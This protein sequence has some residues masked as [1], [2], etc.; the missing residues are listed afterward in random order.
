M[1]AIIRMNDRF[2]NCYSDDFKRKVVEER[3]KH[4][5][6]KDQLRAKYGIKGKSAILDWIRKFGVPKKSP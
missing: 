4:G 1:T 2:V 3:L 5:T 6:P